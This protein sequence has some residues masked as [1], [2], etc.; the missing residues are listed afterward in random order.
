MTPFKRLV[1]GV[2]LFC[3]L[4]LAMP[5]HVAAKTTKANS[6]K[7]TIKVSARPFK[8]VAHAVKTSAVTVGTF[9]FSAFDAAVV[10]PFGVALQA[11]ADGVDMFIA[12]P[13]ESLPRPISYVGDGVHYVYLGVDKVGQVLAK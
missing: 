7:H 8:A 10:D 2:L 12:A 4:A 11:F 5:T 6:T 13:L 3:G 1:L 9:S